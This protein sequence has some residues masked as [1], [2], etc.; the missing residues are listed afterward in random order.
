MQYRINSHWDARTNSLDG[1]IFTSLRTAR[2]EIRRCVGST[3]GVKCNG[4]LILYATRGD[5][6]ADKNGGSPH[7]TVATID[8]DYRPAPKQY[9][10]ADRYDRM[11][12]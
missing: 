7:T 10:S 5:M 4:A 3:Y 2:A 12:Y 8:C 1:Q 6:H 11:S 9:Y